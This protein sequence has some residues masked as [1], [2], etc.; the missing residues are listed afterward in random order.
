MAYQFK[1]LHIEKIA[2]IGAGQIGPDIALHFAKTLSPYKVSV[3]LL[4][5]NENALL[6]A[7][8][9]L[10]S[11]I[12]KA[13]QKK[14]FRP[15][16]V[17]K[18]NESLLFT[19]DYLNVSDA[20]IVIEAATEDEKI[21]NAIFQRVESLTSENCIFLSNSSHMQP[22]AIFRN[23]TDQSRCLVA[24]YFFP[25]EINPVV[26]IVAGKETDPALTKTLLG[27]YEDIGKVPI[28]VKSSYG[29]AVDPI[30]E[31]LCQLAIMCNEKQIGSVKEIDAAAIKALGLGVGPF[32]ALNLTGG[33]PITAH[34]L[35]ELRK[36]L[37]PW[38]S[39]P[40]SLYQKLI[41]NQPWETLQRG[42]AIELPG[43]NEEKL[44]A[45]FQGACFALSGFML[46]TG[47]VDINDLN[48]AV[49]LAL[50]V[51]P[52]FTL[53]NEMGMD[54]TEQLV[55][56]FCNE[57]PAFPFPAS[58]EKAVAAGGWELS[59]IL[60]E[61]HR[62]T[63]LITI[64]RPKVMNAL[65]LDVLAR[66]KAAMQESAT[67][68]GIKAV[69]IT[70][71][72]KKA[73][74]SGADLQMI[75]SL[76]TPDEGIENSQSFQSVLNY[77]AAYPKPVVCALNGFAFGGGSELAVSCT[78]RI[79]IKGL[80]VV[81]SQPEV[82][83]G[84]IPGAGGTQRLPRLIGIHKA[85]EIL[86]TGRT[87]PGDEALHIGYLDKIAESDLLEEATQLA[88][89]IASGKFIAKKQLT[90]VQE[91]HVVPQKINIGTLSNRIDEILVKSIYEGWK[92][93]LPDALLLESK[94][95]GECI[96]T[97]D[98]QIGLENFKSNGPKV[99]AQFVHE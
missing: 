44:I 41:N 11:K 27:F 5:I 49:E 45:L 19:L 31:G 54:R 24:H 38:F 67:D 3:V 25:A 30:F 77:I 32:T 76:K 89:D 42:E 50:V 40:N 29:F 60:L 46:D 63:L 66:I 68:R 13:F 35:E 21:K 12:D 28:N 8:Q 83:L 15:E 9:K 78:A 51:K 52:P 58:L 98:M 93:D 95:F 94:M 55:N 86:R 88:L 70:G 2:V 84:F 18:I 47:I 96:K 7:K 53:M 22:E 82:K 61:K 92:Q 71:F 73:F 80:P 17:S 85:A 64:R 79:A 87:V 48:M 36:Q 37:M 99:P 62:E 4:D 69:V 33:N 91:D 74:V 56:D 72:G 20:Q 6:K 59:D 16:T 97:K 39:T 10:S 81:F 23:V 57:N 1:S 43:K 90:T 26:E 65:N 14:I 75:A 34:G